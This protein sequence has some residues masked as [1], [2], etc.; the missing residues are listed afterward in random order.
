MRGLQLRLSK[1]KCAGREIGAKGQFAQQQ[2]RGRA[3][4]CGSRLGFSGQ[5]KRVR[6]RS[7]GR[8]SADTAHGRMSAKTCC[9]RI[10]ALSTASPQRA[11]LFWVD[12]FSRVVPGAAV[13]R[14]S[15]RRVQKEDYSMTS[16]ARPSSETGTVSPSAFA[17]LRLMISSTF[18]I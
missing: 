2:S 4:G 7:M 11:D 9:C 1:Q 18:V 8:S 13:S 3:V 6:S 15:N 16:S 12:L 5:D 10:K 14:C 17:V